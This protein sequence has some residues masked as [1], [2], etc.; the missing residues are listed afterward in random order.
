[1]EITSSGS[2]NSVVIAVVNYMGSDGGSDVN[3]L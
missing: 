3:T 1:M 2:G